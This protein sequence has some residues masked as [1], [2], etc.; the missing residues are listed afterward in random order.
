MSLARFV[1][2]RHI[3]ALDFI[4]TVQNAFHLTTELINL[5]IDKVAEI[6][7]NYFYIY[8]LILKCKTAALTIEEQTWSKIE[9][10]MLQVPQ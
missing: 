1:T 3:Q 7:R 5:S 9:E 4:K 8:N 6:D 10:R 2:H